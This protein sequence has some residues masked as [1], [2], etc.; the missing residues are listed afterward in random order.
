MGFV[1]RA[2]LGLFDAELNI[3]ESW[4]CVWRIDDRL[5]IWNSVVESPL[6]VCSILLDLGDAV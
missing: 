6:H 2:Q 4:R 5:G 1:G 3:S